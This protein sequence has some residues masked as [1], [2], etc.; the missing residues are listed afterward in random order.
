MKKTVALL[1]IFFP[2]VLL[3]QTRDSA[4]SCKVNV[5]ITFSPDYCFRTLKSNTSNDWM[6]E[7]VDTLEV[8]KFGYTS[9]INV[10]YLL[11]NR[12]TL[13]TGVL[14]ANKGEKTKKYFGS[15]AQIFNYNSQYYYL[16]IPVKFNYYILNKKL[17]LFLTGGLSANVFITHKVTQ[18]AGYTNDDK[19]TAFYNKSGLSKINPSF[20]VGFGIDCALTNKW[21]FK[22]EPLYR[23][24]ITPI[25]NAPIKKYLYSAG[26]NFGF[27][28]KL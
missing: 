23:R 22:L 14:L 11:N 3:C 19:K 25:A 28:Y 5:G 26:L 10:V 20:L 15:H 27:F 7:S 21:Y 6:K 18:I 9:G 13:A 4:K 1:I 2:F 17:K 12:I 16:D 8:A 24:S